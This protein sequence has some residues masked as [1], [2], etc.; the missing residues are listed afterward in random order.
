MTGFQ[1]F[2]CWQ[3]SALGSGRGDDGRVAAV[4][5]VAYQWGYGKPNDLRSLRLLGVSVGNPFAISVP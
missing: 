4:E 3:C 1:Y 5:G 2:D